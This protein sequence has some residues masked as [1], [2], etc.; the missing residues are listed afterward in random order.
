[1]RR[2][3]NSQRTLKRCVAALVGFC[4]LDKLDPVEFIAQAVREALDARRAK[5]EGRR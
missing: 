2:P 4:L 3:K 1:M 5:S